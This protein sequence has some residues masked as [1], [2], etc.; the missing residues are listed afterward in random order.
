M[1]E[2]RRPV[3]NPRLKELIQ[4]YK[5]DKQEETWKRILSEVVM[6]ARF[7]MPARLATP[8]S[9]LEQM[10]S[11]SKPRLQFIMITNDKKEAFFLAFTDEA[12]LRKWIPEQNLQA[13][14]AG[15]DEYAALMAKDPKPAG[16]VINPFGENMVLDRK[17]V[18]EL[19]AQKAALLKKRAEQQ[20]EQE[21]KQEQE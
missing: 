17:L 10:L 21:Q 2:E 4:A 1:A 11:G 7:L 19:R 6:N 18:E 5:Q 14:V 13:A 9:D 15:F 3:E 20:K 12:E 16:M 8:G